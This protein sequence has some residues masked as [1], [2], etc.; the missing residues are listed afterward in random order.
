MKDREKYSK[1]VEFQLTIIEKSKHDSWQYLK[2]ILGK[3]KRVRKK[4]ERS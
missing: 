3:V 2:E 1:E 4:A